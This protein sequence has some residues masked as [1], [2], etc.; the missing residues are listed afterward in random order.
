MTKHLLD[1][2]LAGTPRS[3]TDM[4]IAATAMANGCVVAT[5]NEKHFEG[6]APMINP[7]RPAG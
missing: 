3:R 2:H 5:A 4:V 7:M 6:V 1:G